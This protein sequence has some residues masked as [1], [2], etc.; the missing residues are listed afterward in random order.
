MAEKLSISEANELSYEDFIAKFGNVVEHCGLC[1]AAVWKY[2]PFKNLDSL[3]GA[4]SEF[5]D[6]L[7]LSGKVVTGEKL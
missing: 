6:Q 4:V 2:R 5:L 1:A 3:H 7:P